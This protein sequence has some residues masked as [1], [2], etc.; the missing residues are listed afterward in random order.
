MSEHFLLRN[1]FSPR[2]IYTVG[3]IAAHING[4]IP[5]ERT[6]EK[7]PDREGMPLALKNNS[8]YNNK[9]MPGS[10]REL[11]HFLVS[12]GKYHQ[13]SKG[14]L[15]RPIVPR[16]KHSVAGLYCSPLN[17]SA[18]QLKNHIGLFSNLDKRRE[19]HM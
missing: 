18:Y 5:F 9:T 11:L 12:E 14:Q 13:I 8:C 16:H 10:L 6:I 19:R 2:A 17:L 3:R 4:L 1:I 15:I 7:T